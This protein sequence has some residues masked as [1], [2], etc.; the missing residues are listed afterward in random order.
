MKPTPHSAVALLM[1][2]L[3]AT[4]SATASA[5]RRGSDGDRDR[6][7]VYDQRYGHNRY[8]PQR[9]YRVPL[10]PRDAYVARYRGGSYYYRGGAWYR[11]FGRSFV[12]VAP[13]IGI[14][15]PLL[16]PFYTTVWFG[17]MPYYYA[18]DTY[19]RWA[20]ARRA[21][22]VSEPPSAPDAATTTSPDY[23]DLFVYPKQGQGDE[24]QATD[25]YECHHWAVD[26]T[27]FDPTRPLGGVAADKNAA[28]R[29]DYQ[30]AETACLES[31][32]YTV[33]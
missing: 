24:Q 6:G 10:A 31:R 18:D 12:V 2:T 1:M 20:P 33:K 27:G 22:V 5:G 28:R 13:P 16:P 25:R 3:L 4:L 15:V 26:Q 21:Y 29:S 30:R 32:S 11:P 14:E 19:Y 8:Y 7:R 23:S 17:G 9:G